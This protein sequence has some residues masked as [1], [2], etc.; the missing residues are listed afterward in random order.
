MTDCKEE[1][2]TRQKTKIKIKIGAKNKHKKF[3][4]TFGV[5]AFPLPSVLGV[6]G[7]ECQK[8]PSPSMIDH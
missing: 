5:L 6:L 2:E 3:S 8:S 1:Q 7:F 4:N